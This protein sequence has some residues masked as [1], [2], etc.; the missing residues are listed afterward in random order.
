MRDVKVCSV[1]KSRYQ[2]SLVVD[3]LSP[4]DS[5]K[6]TFSMAIL[7]LPLHE[8]NLMKMQVFHKAW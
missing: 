8:S 4:S 6:K 2:I 7:F 3:S 5:N 1:S